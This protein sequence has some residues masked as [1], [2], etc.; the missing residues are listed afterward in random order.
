[1]AL[2]VGVGRRVGSGLRVRSGFGEALGLAASE[3]D[4]VIT[5]GVRSAGIWACDAMSVPVM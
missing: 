5:I 4:S 2:A 3:G 1:V